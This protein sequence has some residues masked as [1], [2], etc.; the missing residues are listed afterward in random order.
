MKRIKIQ[1]SKYLTVFALTTLIFLL[2]LLFGNF[3]SNTKLKQL[4]NIQEDVKVDSM[5]IELQF[6]LLAEDPCSAINATP[7]TDELYD[8][9]SKLEF[10][11]NSLGKTNKNVLRLKEYYSLLELR[12]WLLLKKTKKEC[13]ENTILILYFYSNMQDCRKCEEQGYVLTY[14]RKKFPNVRLY[15]FDI[16]LGNVA[17]DTVKKIYI[18]KKGLP[19]IV[20]NDNA[21]YGFMDRDAIEKIIS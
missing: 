4:N 12:H 17:L 11:E 9:S 2:G 19:V 7:L 15:A 1:K 21:Y 13:N 5:A 16:N 14:I 3:V 10:M 6:Q 8:L 20:I 18:N